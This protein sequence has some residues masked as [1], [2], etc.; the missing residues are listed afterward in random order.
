MTIFQQDSDY[1]SN[2]EKFNLLEDKIEEL[3]HDL[4][5]QKDY[6]EKSI[7]ELKCQIEASSNQ[8]KELEST[9]KSVNEKL[10]ILLKDKQQFSKD[11]ERTLN[12]ESDI[13][14]L[15]EMAHQQSGL[16]IKKKKQQL[17]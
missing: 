15:M 2:K 4:S 10:E 11:Q 9:I 12:I 7:E 13:S 3:N 17:A 5:S 1:E 14:E 6:Y 16:S 8:R